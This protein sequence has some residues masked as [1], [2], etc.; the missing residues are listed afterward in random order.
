[1]ALAN[2]LRDFGVLLQV[3]VT[4]P[5]TPKEPEVW[6]E[7]GV[8]YAVG[9]DANHEAISVVRQHSRTPAFVKPCLPPISWGSRQVRSAAGRRYFAARLQ[10]FRPDAIHFACFNADKPAYMIEESIRAGAKVILQPWTHQYACAQGFACYREERCTECFDGNFERAR[11][12][13]CQ[14]G[15][16]HFLESRA[17]KRLRAASRECVFFSSCSASDVM[18]LSYGAMPERIIR[19]PL[20]FA[21]AGLANQPRGID[22][23]AFLYH[24]QVKAFK[25]LRVLADTV[26]ALPDVDFL[27]CPPG[28]QVQDFKTLGLTRNWPAKFACPTQSLFWSRSRGTVSVC[29]GGLGAISLGYD[30]RVCFA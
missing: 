11:R 24:G 29:G 2:T 30:P 12:R 23:G 25:G 28:R 18:L 7:F 14:V 15:L 3:L 8:E 5:A 22:K 9:K 20:Q 13:G 27:I 1:M 16:R 6:S 21:P 19:L 10:A 26:R 17:R 4:N